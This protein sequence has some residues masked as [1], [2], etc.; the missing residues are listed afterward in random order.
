MNGSPSSHALWYLSRGTGVVALLLLTLVVVLGVLIRG[1]VRV[2]SLP[3]FVVSG[4]HRN[5]GLLAV[6]FLV[7]HI[8][9]SVIDPYASIRLL[10]AVLPFGSHYR[11]FW[12]GLGA[13]AFDLLLAIV[14]T[15]LARTRMGL[16]SWKA[17]H[18][19]AYA[20][21]PVALL[22]GLGTGTDV[23]Q[24]WMLLLTAACVGSVAAAVIWRVLGIREGRLGVRVA[25][26]AAAVV[27][28]LALLAWLNVGPL[29]PGWAARS[30]TPAYTGGTASG[31][32]VA[33]SGGTRGGEPAGAVGATSGESEH[34]GF[35][36]SFQGSDDGS[37]S[38]DG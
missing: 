33:T 28:P 17:V 6:G 26:G 15:S 36:G 27:A 22:H 31:A 3:R 18:L 16:R 20:A 12:L 14:V 24:G 38:G 11:P 4:L 32:S 7:V 10:D 34:E 29:A 23:R 30:G 37:A 8:A 5:A 19:A 1:N 25:A 35:Q 13:V 2:P 9:T 21:W